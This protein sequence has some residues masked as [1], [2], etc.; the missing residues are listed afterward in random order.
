MSTVIDVVQQFG[1]TILSIARGFQFKDIIDI[2]IIT[3]LIYN[4][5]K[6]FR[7][8]RAGQLVKGILLLV[9]AFLF[10]RYFNL[11]MLNEILR[12][13]FQSAFVFFLIIFQPE[14]RKALELVG[15]SNVGRS[16]ASMVGGKDRL[17]KRPMIY[18]AIDCVV[19]GAAVLQQLRMGALIVFERKT[20][21]H[22]IAASGTTL[23]AEPT[24][25][26]ISNIFYNK[27]PLHDGALIIRDG[28]I[29]AAGCILPLTGSDAVNASLGT[30]HRAALGISEDSDAVVVV[31][32]EET[33]QISIAEK[34]ILT[35][36]YN[37]ITLRET[38]EKYL[39][40]SSDEK[41]QG[42]TI[43]SKFSSR[44]KGADDD[45]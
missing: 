39:L 5:I 35:R 6:F 42:K 28:K 13:F 33:G 12:L 19:E 40:D 43:F 3:F 24:A 36:N 37:R 11:L 2:A 30:R 20:K 17:A 29:L 18:N 34:G 23:D 15:R 45:E 21:L 22:E 38:L 7:E 41:A 31:V 1:E 14:I 4:A 10:S 32:S 16:I 26:L 9:V 25:M 27:A 44:K 8:T